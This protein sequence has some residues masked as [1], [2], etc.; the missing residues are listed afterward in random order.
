MRLMQG[1]IGKGAGRSVPAN[2][3]AGFFPA[4]P[5]GLA[6]IPDVS[7]PVHPWSAAHRIGHDVTANRDN[8]MTIAKITR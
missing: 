1:S 2:K 5:P 8:E 3:K 4:F 6:G 7:P